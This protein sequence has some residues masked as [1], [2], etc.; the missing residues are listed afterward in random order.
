M[1]ETTRAIAKLADKIQDVEKG[2]LIEL[3]S[4]L[5]AILHNELHTEDEEEKDGHRH[6]LLSVAEDVRARAVRESEEAREMAVA[7]LV[8]SVGGDTRHQGTAAAP[9]QERSGDGANRID[10]DPELQQFVTKALQTMT[11]HEAADACRQKFGAGHASAIA[12]VGRAALAL[13]E[14]RLDRIP[15]E[16][17]AAIGGAID[18]KAT[19]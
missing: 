11:C 2:S 19:T 3:G 1:S 12:T 14:R 18:P 7:L 4:V 17:D 8:E 9:H 6:A 15:G 13:F 10:V 16:A 5:N